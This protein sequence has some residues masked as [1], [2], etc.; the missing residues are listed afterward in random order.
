L[1]RRASVEPAAEQPITPNLASVRYGDLILHQQLG[2]GGMGKVYRASLRGSA[3]PVAVKLL[4]KPL[5]QHDASAA[6]FLHE[7]EL[8]TRLRHPGIVA[9][10][11]LGQLPDGGHFLVMDLVEGSDLARRLA[12]GPIP[13][14]QAVEWVREAAVAIAHAHEQGIVHC[15][16]K[17]S[18]LLLDRAG[19]IRVSDFGLAR[20]LADGG[21]PAGGTAGF[22]AP[23]QIDPGRGPIT[24][25]TDVY[26][27]GAVLITLL[28]GRSPLAGTSSSSSDAGSGAVVEPAIPAD[29]PGEVAEL[30]R[31]C[32]AHEPEHRP[33]SAAELIAAL[34]ALESS[35]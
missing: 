31:R 21:P 12:G 1:Q 26:G 24:T 16:L 11:A 7:A 33:A 5:R 9:I 15:D 10:H 13:V 8:L 2:Q 20:S 18:N 22:M 4:R 14:R 29:V 32:L 23:E 27:L 28:G 19:R 30:C 25:R 17:P 3:V 6:R 34:R 35:L